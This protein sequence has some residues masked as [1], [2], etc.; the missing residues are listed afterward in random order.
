MFALEEENLNLNRLK[1]NGT[2]LVLAS[3]ALADHPQVL[4]PI[5]LYTLVQNLVAGAVDT[6]IIRTSPPQ[7]PDG[8]SSQRAPLQIDVS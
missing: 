4:L 3:M 1:Y 8:D 2:G 7:S 6:W 5:I